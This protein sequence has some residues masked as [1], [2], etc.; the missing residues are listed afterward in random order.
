MHLLYEKMMHLNL[1][2][3][4]MSLVTFCLSHLQRQNHWNDT[5]NIPH[6][7]SSTGDRGA[8]LFLSSR[9]LICKLMQDLLPVSKSSFASFHKIVWQLARHNHVV[10]PNATRTYFQTPLGRASWQR[11]NAYPYIISIVCLQ[12]TIPLTWVNKKN[13]NRI[14]IIW[15][16]VRLWHNYN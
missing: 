1:H 2:V 5:H 10:R 14:V 8:P 4:A 9:K 15:T 13:K 6:H 3:T 12:S 16:S 7:P 11:M